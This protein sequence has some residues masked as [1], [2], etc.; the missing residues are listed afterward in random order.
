MEAIYKWIS[1]LE[2]LEGMKYFAILCSALAIIPYTELIAKY[3]KQIVLRK[4]LELV[5]F[6]YSYA[7]ELFVGKDENGADIYMDIPEDDVFIVGNKLQL[8]WEVKGCRRIDIT[9][10]GKN[11]KG[12]AASV[13][14]KENISE[15]NLT[16]YG[17]WGEKITTTIQIPE[18]QKYKLETTKLSAYSDSII[19]KTPSVNTSPLTEYKPYNSKFFEN[20]KRMRNWYREHLLNPINIRIHCEKIVHADK[21]KKK[22]YSNLDAARLT[23]GYSF[24]TKNYN[25]ELISKKI[26]K[27]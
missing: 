8:Y 13:I 10:V 21:K 4:K 27:Y 11:L 12:N 2:P 23:K 26:I 5:F 6:E 19:R 14:I 25:T 1:E 3:I 15:Y 9:H 24:S 7:Q 17:F 18:D 20:L 22:L 16:A